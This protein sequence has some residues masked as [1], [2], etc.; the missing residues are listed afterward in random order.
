MIA[1]SNI[2][3]TQDVSNSSLSSEC[4]T[5]I[6]MTHAAYICMYV[7]LWVRVCV[8]VYTHVNVVFWA[9][10]KCWKKGSWSFEREYRLAKQISTQKQ[11]FPTLLEKQ[12]KTKRK[13]Q[14]CESRTVRRINVESKGDVRV[15]ASGWTDHRRRHCG[16]WVWRVIL[17]LLVLLLVVCLFVC[18]FEFISKLC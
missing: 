16:C 11:T 1:I 12:N 5:S 18:V 6:L 7:C 10:R 14:L 15:D 3:L 2:A 9:I 4:K 8:C 17:V 13:W